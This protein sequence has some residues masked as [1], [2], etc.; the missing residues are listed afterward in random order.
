METVPGVDSTLLE[1][2]IPAL[3]VIYIESAVEEMKN[4][5]LMYMMSELAYHIAKRIQHQ[6][7]FY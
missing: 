6:N 7:A 2:H 1:I 3:D 5:D 4:D